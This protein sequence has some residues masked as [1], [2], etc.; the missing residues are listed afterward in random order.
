MGV[1]DETLEVG[2]HL[3]PSKLVGQEVKGILNGDW[4]WVN[5][6]VLEEGLHLFHHQSFHHNGLSLNVSVC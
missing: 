6:V 5:A 3:V 2:S 4:G 1:V